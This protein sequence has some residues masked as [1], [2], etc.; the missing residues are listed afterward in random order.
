MI[1]NGLTDPLTQYQHFKAMACE[2]SSYGTLIE[3]PDK[4]KQLENDQHQCQK[5]IQKCYKSS[6]QQ[7][8]KEDCVMAASICN[9]FVVKPILD[10]TKAVNMYDIRRPCE[11]EW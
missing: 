10:S 1:G 8:L 5:F 11:G 3:S 7:Q 4:C 9:S 2:P 6:T